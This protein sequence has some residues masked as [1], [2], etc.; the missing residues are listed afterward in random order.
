MAKSGLWI[1]VVAW[2]CAMGCGD[3]GSSSLSLGSA[4]VDGTIGGAAFEPVSAIAGTQFGYVFV[5]TY[6]PTRHT[7]VAI[8]DFADHCGN[9]S[10][11]GRTLYVSLFENPK[12]P[13]SLVS[14]PG[15]FDVWLPSINGESDPGTGNRAVVTFA[16]VSEAGGSARL[17]ESG[18]VIVERVSGEEIAGSFD[19]TFG[20]DRL[21]GSFRTPICETWTRSDA[22][23]E[24][25]RLSYSATARAATPIDAA[26]ARWITPTLSTWPRAA[27]RS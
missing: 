7:A 3:G 14:R 1:A 13:V 10:V 12:L 4:V 2:L 21:T 16:Q 6:L 20:S 25:G 26:S 9:Q 5:F 15:T 24:P 19:V 11:I 27:K 8:S 23:P 17:A 22:I 18:K